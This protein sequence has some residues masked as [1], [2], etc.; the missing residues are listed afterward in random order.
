MNPS[1]MAWQQAMIKQSMNFFMGIPHQPK[2]QKPVEEGPAF[3]SKDTKKFPRSDLIEMAEEEQKER[4]TRAHLDQLAKECKERAA[5]HQLADEIHA[6]DLLD[7]TTAAFKA[8]QA[9]RGLP[10][11]LEA[12]AFYGSDNGAKIDETSTHEEVLEA[13]HRAHQEHIADLKREREAEIETAITDRIAARQAWV[14]HEMARNAAL[15]L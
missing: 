5:E 14:R 15:D 7:K 4:D 13:L 12:A 2:T 8:S 3:A 10:S 6:K 11:R 1:Y 9:K